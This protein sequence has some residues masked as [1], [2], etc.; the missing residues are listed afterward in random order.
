MEF[1]KHRLEAEGH[2][3]VVLNIGTSRK[4]PST[5]YVTVLSGPDFVRKLW[6]HA[7]QG[8]AVHAHANG[9]SPTGLGLALLAE[10]IAVLNRRR[11]FLTFHA[12]AIQRHFPVR[13]GRLFVPLFRLLFMMPRTIICNSEAVKA[14]IMEYGIAPEKIVP[15]PA[16]SRQYLEYRP[17]TLPAALEEFLGRFPK[18]VFTYVRMRPLFYPLTMIDGVAELMRRRSDVGLVLCGGTG[19]ADQGVWPA[20]QAAIARHGIADR[21]CFVDDLDHDAFLTVMQRAS[22]YLRTPIT[23][24]VASSVLEALA[25]GVPVVACDNGTRPSGVITYPVE[26]ATALADAVERVL[27]RPPGEESGAETRAAVPDTLADEVAVLTS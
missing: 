4:I 21:I 16:F 7:R 13:K 20:V 17:A 14:C 18:T 9:D 11:C 1:L 26:E 2:T 15:I 27:I 10:F 5:E 6:R 3:C 22:V 25:L 8:F 24:G 19:H 23:D 12:G